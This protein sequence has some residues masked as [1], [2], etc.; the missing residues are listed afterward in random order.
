M[1][2]LCVGLWLICGLLLRGFAA[3]YFK[4]VYFLCAA[5]VLVFLLVKDSWA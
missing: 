4:S 3:A 1:C 5:L 2:P